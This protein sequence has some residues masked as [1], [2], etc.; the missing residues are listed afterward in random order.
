MPAKEPDPEKLKQVHRIVLLAM[1]GWMS[2][3][4]V[5]R[6]SGLGI[7]TVERLCTE[8][9]IEGIKVDGIWRIYLEEVERFLRY[10]D[11]PP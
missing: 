4:E 10:G 9:K 2:L 11:N 1:R 3:A 5:A 7:K 8:G 6:M